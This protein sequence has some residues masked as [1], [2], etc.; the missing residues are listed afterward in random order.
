MPPQSWGSA[1]ERGI[2]FTTLIGEIIELLISEILVV[3]C[4]LNGN[5]GEDTDGFENVHEGKDYRHQNPDGKIILDMCTGANLAITK[6]YFS[7]P[8]SKSTTY[9]S[10]SK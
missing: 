7:K 2:F 10:D 1:T 5:I 9:K 3:A 8:N 4:N 6:A